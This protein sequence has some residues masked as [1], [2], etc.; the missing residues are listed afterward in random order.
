MARKRPV[1]V[2]VIRQRPKREPKFHQAE[3][4]E[5]V[6]RSTRASLAIFS[7]GCVFRRLAICVLVVEYNGGFSSHWS[8]LKSRQELWLML[9]IF[10]YLV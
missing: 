8:W 2:W 10:L 7:S 3:M 6:G 9:C 5:G 1:I 4:L